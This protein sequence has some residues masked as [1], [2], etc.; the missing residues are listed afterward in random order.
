MTN[1]H[2]LT[3]HSPV[4][5]ENEGA[6]GRV[7]I[8]VDGSDGSMT[9]LLWAMR[10]ARLRAATLHAVLAWS[11]HPSWDSSGLGS[12]FPMSYGTGSPTMSG[13]AP[14]LSGEIASPVSVLTPLSGGQLNAETEVSNALDDE[15]TRAVASDNA[16]THLPALTITRQVVDG[17]PAHALLDAVTESD[18]LVVGSHGHGELTGALLGSISQHVV[19]HC[20]CPVVVV[21]DPRHRRT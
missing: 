14:T 18:L 6:A 9:A 17:H 13:L 11:Y 16:G 8:G 2:A 20:H 5:A 7:V 15:I 1:A 19:S 4:S 10:E 3:A 21:P 12:M